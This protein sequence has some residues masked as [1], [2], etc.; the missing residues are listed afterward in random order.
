MNFKKT[1]KFK[2]TIIKSITILIILI[3]W[4]LLINSSIQAQE[5]DNSEIKD[6]EFFFLN[7]NKQKIDQYSIKTG[8]SINILIDVAA[9]KNVQSISGQIYIPIEYISILNINAHQDFC[10]AW[11]SKPIFK[12]NAIEFICNR[13][14]PKKNIGTLITLTLVANKNLNSE[15]IQLKK[16]K[17]LNQET[18]I[19]NVP[20]IYE[21]NIKNKNF[22]P[23]II[24]TSSE[25]EENKQESS[26]NNDLIIFINVILVFAITLSIVLGIRYYK[27]TSHDIKK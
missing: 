1:I 6:I 24:Q 25:V 16:I 15:N 22:T 4:I 9:N 21:L 14:N 17:Y 13:T 19:I 18:D 23:Q 10:Q 20:K 3:A 26:I 11:D 12:D 7:E 8:Q 2:N 27:L 5:T